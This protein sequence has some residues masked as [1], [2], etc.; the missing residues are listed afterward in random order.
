MR[1]YSL[2]HTLIA[3]TL[4]WIVLAGLGP[5]AKA[6]DLPSYMAPIS[7]R[8]VSSP[9][10]TAVKNVL[11]LNTGMFELYD[12]AAKIFER[13]ILAK[14]P[15]IL[16]LFSGAGGRFIL[17]RPGMAPLEAPSV[18]L[19]YQ[20][21]KSI[22]HSTMALAQVVGPYLDNP[23]DQSW[24]GPMLAYRARMTSALD[25]LDQTPMPPEWRG[26]DRTVSP[27]KG[28]LIAGCLATRALSF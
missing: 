22:D 17:Y 2:L 10:E 24:R 5:M 18:P 8:T 16:G 19:V 28:L 21:L 25:G 4:T 20:L 3:A 15:V 23:T 27:N 26:H 9:A 14:H 13:N 12:N 11:A 6:Q 7:G 1:A